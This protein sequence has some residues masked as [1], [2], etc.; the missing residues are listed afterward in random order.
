VIESFPEDI[1]GATRDL[2][3]H[4][5]HGV[6]IAP[7]RLGDG[8]SPW[9]VERALEATADALVAV[10]MP[11]LELAV[12]GG[13]VALV[14]TRPSSGL[15]AVLAKVEEALTPLMAAPL[16]GA[17]RGARGATGGTKRLSQLPA[18]AAH[19]FHM[20]FTDRMDI[21]DAFR[22][23]DRLDP[24]LAPMLDEPRKIA[25]LALMADPGGGRPLRVLQRFD[26]RETPA[27]AQDALPCF[28]R[29]NLV[30]LLPYPLA[31]TGVA[32]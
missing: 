18:S 19:R 2:C 6:V 24:V 15:E 32:V 13:Q 26:L 28:G 7:F 25:E 4:G 29:P 3:L 30:Q 17:S 20:P 16:P 23:R 11:P 14:P 31:D 8:H 21:A 1:A 12:T 10:P 5:F 27:L 9:S 22:I